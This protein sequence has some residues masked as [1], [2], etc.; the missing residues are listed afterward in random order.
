MNAR[1]KQTMV[2]GIVVGIAFLAAVVFAWVVT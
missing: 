1:D 2:V